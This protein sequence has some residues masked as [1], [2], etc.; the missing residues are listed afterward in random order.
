MNW[1]TYKKHT[2]EFFTGKKAVML[3]TITTVGGD[4]FRKGSIVI[5]DGKR[6]VMTGYLTCKGGFGLIKTR[7]RKNGCVIAIKGV[8]PEDIELI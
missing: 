7:R 6:K 4:V 5:I 1:T 3:R 2:S 8:D